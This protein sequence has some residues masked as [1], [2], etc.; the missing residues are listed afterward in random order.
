MPRFI[1]YLLSA[2][3]FLAVALPA[4]AGVYYSGEQFAELPSQW[5]GF[6][7]DQRLLRQ[8]A[9]KPTGTQTAHPVR[10]RYEEAAATLEKTARQRPLT[11]DESADLG[12]LYIRLGDVAKAVETLRSAQRE[13]RQH[14]RTVANL[15]T[16]WQLQGDLPQAA[17]ALQE[18]VRLAPGKLQRAEE[19]QLKLVRF[20]QRQAKDAQEL[21]DLFGIRY[22]GA[23]GNY[24][25]G[26]LAPP[27]S[28]KL[29]AD[30]VGLVQQLALWLP[31][32][33][34]LLWQLAE[35]ANAHGDVKTAAA[36][37]DGCVTEFNM[38]AAELRR[39]RQ[40][41]RDAADRLA[42]A[43]PAGEDGKAAHEGHTGIKARSLRP[44]VTKLEHVD[45]PPV[46]ATGV[47]QLPWSVLI[48][49]TVDRHFKPT[50]A[51]YLRELDGKE[52]SLLG[53]MQPLDENPELTSFMFIEY[54]V[55]C[56]YCEMPEVTGI[57]LVDLPAGKTHPFT[58]GLVK[59]T[60]KLTLNAT[61]PENF[62]YTISKAR[63]SGAD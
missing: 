63:V 54:P 32:D 1:A 17:A 36:I 59:V 34:R 5:R 25:P 11:A 41:T 21:D 46:T 42:K 33:G 9:V 52:V 24:E 30:A 6:L 57:V 55:G 37:M 43:S 51:K 4:R 45:L 19:L 15:G 50:F 44:L 40:L 18:A 27:E 16:A 48:D 60:G 3:F 7:L 29:P 2:I 13:H 58:R 35:L 20:R 31:A 53:F 23:G 10:L 61:D 26:T 39:H 14:F 8:I 56:W 22:V 12:A 62:L 47:N 38:A 28:K 49:T